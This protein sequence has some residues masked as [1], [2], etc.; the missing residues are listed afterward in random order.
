MNEPN[1]SYSKDMRQVSQVEFILR[2]I[3]K[4]RYL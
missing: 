4:I 1:R 2:I 3:K